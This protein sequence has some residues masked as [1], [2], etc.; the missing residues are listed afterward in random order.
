LAALRPA[1]IH[2]ALFLIDQGITAGELQL[3]VAEVFVKA[4]ASRARMKN[5]RVNQSRV[6]AM[7]GCTRTEVRR[8]VGPMQKRDTTTEDYGVRRA[9]VGWSF[10][11]EFKTKSGS[12]KRL[13]L[14][15][16]YG[17]FS[18]LAKKYSA[19]I[20]P[21]ATLDELKRINAVDISCGFVA[22][23]SEPE[24]ALRRHHQ[25]IARATQQLVGVFKAM[26][27]PDVVAPTLIFSGDTELNTA[28]GTMDRMVR[29]RVEQKTKAY[30]SSL[31]SAANVFASQSSAR[32]Y[33]RTSRIKVV[34][35]ITSLPQ[36]K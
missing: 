36:A 32:K 15:G 9:L 8:L 23:R 5:G 17:S 6:A 14:R 2:L 12:P 28:G 18:R 24:V 33:R 22:Q 3:A 4:A 29:Q 20:P 30:L 7:T 35:S 27:Y 10:D 31:A 13:P 11:P 26:G 34:V 1:L 25:N 19:D 21:K 16:G